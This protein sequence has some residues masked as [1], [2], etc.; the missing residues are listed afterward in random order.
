MLFA[1]SPDRFS[2][3]AA[4]LSVGFRHRLNRRGH[5]A[6]P[7]RYGA[8][9]GAAQAML[10]HEYCAR[11]RQYTATLAVLI[12]MSMSMVFAVIIVAETAVAMLDFPAG[13]RRSAG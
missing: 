12:V 5:A 1:P 10:D 3:A 6:P 7:I 8:K 2:D 11:N 9:R 13:E 4:I